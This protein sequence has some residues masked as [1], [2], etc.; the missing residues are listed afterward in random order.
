MSV[1]SKGH[2]CLH[3]R[4]KLDDGTCQV[5]GFDFGGRYWNVWKTGGC[6]RGMS[7][8]SLVL[9]GKLA[10]SKTETNS[11]RGGYGD[12]C[13]TQPRSALRS[14]RP[15]RIALDRGSDRSDSRRAEGCLSS[16]G[17]HFLSRV[18]ENT[19]HALSLLADF[20]ALNCGRRILVTGAGAALIPVPD[21]HSHSTPGVPIC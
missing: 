4:S 5:S 18:F 12:I 8:A 10:L 20:L 16:V 11:K 1:I 9:P 7:R 14:N 2:S 13:G 17:R 21:D 15:I 3:C 19:L 6:W